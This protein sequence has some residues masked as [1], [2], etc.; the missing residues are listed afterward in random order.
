MDCGRETASAAAGY[1]ANS[2]EECRAAAW[3]SRIAILSPFALPDADDHTCTV[4]IPRRQSNGLG[5]T[6][7]RRV[8]RNERRS[9]L[10]IGYRLEQMLDLLACENSG[11]MIQPAGHR[12]LPGHSRPP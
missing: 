11:E 6:Q 9:Q 10:E 3:I 1:G 2:R 7:T 5:D 12:D 4:D 8:D